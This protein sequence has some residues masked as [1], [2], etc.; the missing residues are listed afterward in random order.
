MDNVISLS[1][2]CFDKLHIIEVNKQKHDHMVAV[3]S[4]CDMLIEEGA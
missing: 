1:K 3:I 4:Y 2:W